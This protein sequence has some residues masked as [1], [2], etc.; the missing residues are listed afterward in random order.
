MEVIKNLQDNQKEL[1]L[2]KFIKEIIINSK[3]QEVI[4][5]GK[6]LEKEIHFKPMQ[7]TKRPYLQRRMLPNVSQITQEAGM[8]KL[9]I[10]DVRLPERFSY[11][12]PLPEKQEL[13][14]GKLNEFI[15]NPSVK[16]IECNGPGEEIILKNPM[17]K[18]TQIVLN[19]SEIEEV[20]EE[21]AKKAKIPLEKGVIRI[22]AGGFLLTGLTSE[23][24]GSK[25][26]IKRI[27]QNPFNTR[28]GIQP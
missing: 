26:I 23:V 27:N 1:F 9:I 10:P 7:F 13:D 15:K 22:A 8:P 5:V 2:L 4:Q 14:L 20:L 28:T 18:K 16:E 12:K 19:E 24:V 17:P 11:L 3:T 25:F 21:F 6:R